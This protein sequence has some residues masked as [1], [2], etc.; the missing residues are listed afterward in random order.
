MLDYRGLIAEATGAN[1]FLVQDGKIHT[2]APDCFLDGITRRTVIDLA[3]R[4][5]YEVIERQIQPEELEKKQEVFLTGT[6]GEV[7]PVAG[8]DQYRLGAGQV[9]TN[10]MEYYDALCAQEAGATA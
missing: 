3:R 4:R 1:V 8:T 5:G 2:P 10:R 7:T 6:A 9:N